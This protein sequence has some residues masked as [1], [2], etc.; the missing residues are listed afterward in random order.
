LKA[1]NFM[2]ADGRPAEKTVRVEREPG[3]QI[4]K[5]R[6]NGKLSENTQEQLKQVLRERFGPDLGFAF[7]D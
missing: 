3:T 7:L 2:L 4:M 6:L 1:Q 5:I